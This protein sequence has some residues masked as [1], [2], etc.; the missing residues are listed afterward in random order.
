M[1]QRRKGTGV[2]RIEGLHVRNYRALRDLTLKDLK[3]LTVLVGPNGSGKSTL[4]DVFAFLADCFSIGLRKAWDKRGR[5]RELRTRGQD[6]PVVIELKYRE[7]P[8]TPLIT[9]HLE[10][11]ETEG[12]PILEAEWLH[13]KRKPFGAPYRFL[14]FKRGQGEVIEGE[15]PDEEATR[16]EE[17]LDTPDTLAVSTLGQLARH[18]RIASLR[19]FITGWYLSYLSAD[20]ARGV[21]EAG[22]Q[23]RLSQSGDNLPNVIQYLK[24]QH[25]ERIEEI[26]RVLRERIPRLERVDTDILADGRLLLRFKDAPFQEPV[27]AKYVSDGTLKMLAYLTVLYD[28]DPPPLVGIEEPEN[29]LHPRLLPGLAEECRK[30]TGHAQLLVTTHSPS[31][32]NALTPQ[33]VWV[34][35]RDLEGFT[36]AKRTAEMTG[37]PDFVA[38]GGQLGDLWL[39]GF[40]DAGDPLAPPQ[41]A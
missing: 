38:E 26:L 8:Q 11:G 36:R 29:Y 34:L 28:P 7:K 12:G 15:V 20:S 33:E 18:P 31:F 19:R 30:A 10:I 1:S 40:F 24:E 5:F 3:P 14:N 13:W 2:P 41:D 6:G 35:Y 23:E 21:P 22:A 17:T 39:E 16:I 32:V 37:V 4:F 25:P 27:L 9:Y